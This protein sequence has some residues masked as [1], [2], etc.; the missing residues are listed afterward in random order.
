[1]RNDNTLLLDMLLAIR[2]IL[3]FTQDMGRAEFMKSELVQSA[4]LREIQVI[5]EAARH[6][7]EETKMAHPQIPWRAM[8]GMRHRIIH[9]YFNVDLAILWE[10]IQT[11][12]PVLNDQLAAIVSA[13]NDNEDR[14]TE[15]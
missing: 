10:T 4:V 7:R 11:D 13:E 15:C 5:G 2:R 9:A 8:I 3:R 6:V 14:D 1:M 12:I